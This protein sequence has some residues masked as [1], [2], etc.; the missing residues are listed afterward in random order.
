LLFPESQNVCNQ[1]IKKQASKIVEALERDKE[2]LKKLSKLLFSEIAL[3]PEKRLVILTRPWQVLLLVPNLSQAILILIQT[4][5][6]FS[7][8]VFV[9]LFFIT[10]APKI[11]ISKIKPKVVTAGV[12]W[13]FVASSKAWT[14]AFPFIDSSP[15]AGDV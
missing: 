7:I 6:V 5:N 14:M 4:Y 8:T 9:R 1:S 3:D 2:F 10:N 11:K 15:V 13:S 12:S